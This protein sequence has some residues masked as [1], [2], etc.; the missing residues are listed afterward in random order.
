MRLRFERLTNQVIFGTSKTIQTDTIEG[1]K[2]EF[3]PVKKSYC[4]FYQLTQNQTYRLIGMKIE[5]TIVIAVRSRYHASRFQLAKIVGDDT[6][7]KVIAI[8]RGDPHLPNEFDLI[9]LQ[10]IAKVGADNG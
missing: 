2:E 5:G 7:Y 4:A 3:V 9:T 1:S 8:S 6:L 10:D